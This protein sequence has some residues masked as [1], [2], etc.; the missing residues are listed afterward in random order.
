MMPTAGTAG[1]VFAVRIARRDFT[2]MGVNTNMRTQQ[3]NVV[4]DW[5]PQAGETILAEGVSYPYNDY[6][7][8][9][10]DNVLVVGGSG[11]GKTRSIVR[12]NLLQ[13]T[14]SYV[15]SDPKG[16]LY[17]QYAPYLRSQGYRVERLDFI[18]PLRS[19]VYYNFF[20]YI[21]NETDIF[22]VA[23]MLSDMKVS[24]TFDRF[25]EDSATLLMQAILCMLWEEGDSSR[26]N[27]SE[28][29]RLIRAGGRDDRDCCELDRLM[30]RHDERYPGSSAMKLYKATSL[31]PNRTW[32]C[33]LTS[34]LTKYGSYDTKELTWLM[35]KDTLRME[36]IGRRPTAVFVVVSDTDRSMDILANLFFSQSM[37][38]L[39]READARQDSRHPV[40]V[41]FILDDFAT[42]VQIKEFPRM[43][44]S[45]RSRGISAM[46]MIQ[47]EA[48]LAAGYGDDAETIIGNCDT[49]V[50]L[51]GNDIETARRVGQRC[52]RPML[53]ILYGPLRDCRVF[54]RGQAPIHTRTFDL[55]SFEKARMEAA[56]DAMAATTEPMTI[57]DR[58][59]AKEH[60]A[61]RKHR[62]NNEAGYM[63]RPV[64][65]IRNEKFAG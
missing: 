50:Y 19:T 20:H 17:D 46:L 3:N 41:R 2:R 6:L 58:L 39:C 27:L 32:S 21:R 7:S 53:E 25:W 65:Y 30:E 47:A 63:S 29:N 34:A 57:G 42:N 36:T 56:R 11:S 28:I 23:Y 8:G 49:Y 37:Q 10:N 40:P 51:G 22:K 45:I 59:A 4:T 61:A 62:L 5:Q 43:I 33:V 13:A 52:D 54:R 9:L 12:P 26:Q 44:A 24:T 1:A 55:D 60:Q 48:Q 18:D 64:A 15:V 16:N 31:N 35:Q 14:G 38:V